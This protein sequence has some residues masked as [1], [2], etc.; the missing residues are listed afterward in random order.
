MS[1]P[2]CET[3]EHFYPSPFEADRGE[4]FDPTKIIYFG[5]GDRRNSE[6]EVFKSCECSNHSPKGE[7]T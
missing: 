1:G 5:K 4:C 7:K 2:Y 6:P 3:C